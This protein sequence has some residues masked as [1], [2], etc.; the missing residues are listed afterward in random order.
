MEPAAIGSLTHRALAAVLYAGAT[1]DEAIRAILREVLVGARVRQGD[2]GTYVAVTCGVRAYLVRCHPGP[3]WTLAA[4]E[5]RLGDV[6][7]DFVFV[8]AAGHDVSNAPVLV[9]ELKSGLSPRVINDAR[10]REQLA[11]LFVASQERWGDR[12]YGVRLVVPALRI[13][14]LIRVPNDLMTVKE[15]AA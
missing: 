5:Y 1:S 9:D 13:A 14:H 11:R 2:R 4:A 15:I 3:E 12:L 10:T 6:W 7:A 8:A